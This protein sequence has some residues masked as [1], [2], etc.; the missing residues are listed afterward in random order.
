MSIPPSFSRPHLW[1]LLV[2]MCVLAGCTSP[3]TVKSQRDP[4]FTADRL[5]RGGAVCVLTNMKINGRYIDPAEAEEERIA[6]SFFRSK[7]FRIVPKVA[8][9][10][11]AFIAVGKVERAIA[12]GGSK[13]DYVH[14]LKSRFFSI[15]SNGLAEREVWTGTAL[16]VGSASNPWK[17]KNRL[18]AES[19]QRFPN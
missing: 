12:V 16:W 15:G 3:A 5:A 7:G 6:E 10:N 2:A 11:Y 9:A 19:L 13:S 1:L 4:S 17:V 8:D 18:L 14:G